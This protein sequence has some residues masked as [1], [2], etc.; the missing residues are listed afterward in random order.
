VRG[1]DVTPFLLDRLRG[2]TGGRSVF[3]NLALL[4]DNAG[5]AAELAQALVQAGQ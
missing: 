4:R 5:V 3:S 2:F 1:R